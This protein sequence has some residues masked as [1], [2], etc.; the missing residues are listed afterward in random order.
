VILYPEGPLV[1][2]VARGLLLWT[3]LPRRKTTAIGGSMIVIAQAVLFIFAAMLVLYYF[4]V[5]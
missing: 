5:V 1:P 3:Y 2:V 4:N